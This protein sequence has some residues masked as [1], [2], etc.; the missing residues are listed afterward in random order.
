MGLGISFR[1]GIGI[2]GMW[3][4]ANL[5]GRAFRKRLLGYL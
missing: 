4:T 2:M 5:L 1:R 3:R